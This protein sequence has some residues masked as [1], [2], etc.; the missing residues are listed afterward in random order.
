[1]KILLDP[2]KKIFRPEMA[3]PIP[4]SSPRAAAPLPRCATAHP[5]GRASRG[6]STTG[7]PAPGG[8]PGS[9]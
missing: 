7:R 5:R 3:S 4:R 6:R 2:P 1:M 8:R 9:R